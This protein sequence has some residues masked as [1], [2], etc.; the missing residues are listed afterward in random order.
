MIFVELEEGLSVNEL[1]KVLPDETIDLIEQT[2]RAENRCHFTDVEI[3][4]KK[5]LNGRRNETML[6]FI[7]AV[8]TRR[9][10]KDHCTLVWKK[11]NLVGGGGKKTEA[12]ERR[13]HI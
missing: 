2:S 11:I 9:M 4:L 6:H 1:R 3:R 10:R 7:S 13:K 12:K 5:Y 8:N